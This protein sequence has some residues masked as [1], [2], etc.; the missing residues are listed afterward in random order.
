M[1]SKT[2]ASS[3]ASGLASVSEELA[4]VFEGSLDHQKGPPRP[5]TLGTLRLRGDKPDR[6][7]MV[8]CGADQVLTR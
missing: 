7:A 3:A 8:V 1:P 2:D 6:D 4:S 5:Q